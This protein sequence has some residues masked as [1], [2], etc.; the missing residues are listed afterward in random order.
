MLWPILI[1]VKILEEDH[2]NK[3]LELNNFY[4]YDPSSL[5]L[6]AMSHCNPFSPPVWELYLL[7][8]LLFFSI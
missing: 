5:I 6:H 2:D 8:I 1:E 4:E 7:I 3:I